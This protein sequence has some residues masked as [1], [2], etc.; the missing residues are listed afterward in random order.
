M[1][2]LWVLVA[3]SYGTL[4]AQTVTSF[5]GSIAAV[6]TAGT[7]GNSTNAYFGHQAGT[8]VTTGVNNTF[9][10]LQSGQSTTTG[11]ENSALGSL[12][13]QQNTTGARNTANGIYALYGN[14]IGME[15]TGIGYSTLGFN[16][17][18]NGN[19]AAGTRALLQ[20]TAGN[21]NSAIGYEALQNNFNSNYNIAMGYRSGQANTGGSQN[22]FLGSESGLNNQ[23]SGNIFLG[24]QAGYNEAG[25]N[26]LYID[27]SNT[28]SPLIWGD[29]AGNLLNLNASVGINITAPTAALDVNG[30]VRLR[31]LNQDNA[32]T[33][34]MVSDNNG[35]LNWR[36]AATLS[37]GAP[38]NSPA[39]TGIPTAP[40][41]AAGTNTTQLATTAFVTAADNLKANL[42]S[43]TFTGT[44][45][46]PT[47]VGNLTG[48]AT[49]ATTVTTNANLTGPV[50]SVGNVTSITNGAITN[51]MLANTAVA[52]LSGTNT[53]DQNLAPYALLNSPTF[54][55]TPAAPTAAAGTNT[56]QLATTAFVTAADNLKANLASPALTG[57]PTAPTAAPGTNTTQLATT[58][59]VTAAVPG[60]G[61]FPSYPASAGDGGGTTNAYFGHEAG[62]VN[63][64]TNNTF[65]GYRSGYN[66]TTGTDNTAYG[67]QALQNNTTGVGNVAIGAA[68]AI[69]GS[70]NYNT[71]V[72]YGAGYGAVFGGCTANNATAIG[73]GAQVTCG[74]QVRIGNNTVTSIGGA[75]AWSNPSD[76]RFK[77]NISEED[78]KGLAFINRLRPVV[79][80]FDTKKFTEFLTQTMP[81]SIRSHHLEQDF[82]PSTAI[83]QSGFIA[84]E[85]EKAAE[86]VGYNFN[87][88]Y[89]PRGQNDHYSLAYSQFVVPLVKGM[90]EQQEMITTQQ[91]LIETLRQEV[92][93]LKG[94]VMSGTI[95]DPIKTSAKTTGEEISKGFQLYQN[96]PNPFSEAT[97]IK[98]VVPES[99]QQAKILVYNLQGVELES[100]PLTE[101]G[102][103]SV[104]ISGGRFVSGMY[105]YALVADGKVIDTKKMI[106]TK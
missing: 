103:V 49:T 58:A 53:G 88:I 20:N 92:E 27:N 72:G 37:G 34:V 55:G 8:S 12:T 91:Q 40:T 19:I 25:S 4:N 62:L 32:L 69:G 106:L 7:T 60:G 51:A 68:I 74:D 89:K 50:T 63:T 21:Y 99:V 78:V 75:V 59:F 87:G 81:D 66:N 52:N 38:L 24:Y 77:D 23:G 17:T 76:G 70:G 79:Y 61:T 13:L 3:V 2:F 56:T 36:D 42:A 11:Y 83:R 101:R 10:G 54:T 26:R 22:T 98:A 97:I 9:V 33:R 105:L 44:V 31:T 46:A 45:T 18:G 57:I 90:Q 28:S 73:N 100:Y 84:Q 64:G 65:S 35:N 47:F 39:F 15:N 29:F 86:E 30:V 5:G 16:T 6:T 93:A 104:E 41:A 102:N 80:N 96:V 67:Y 71:A 14:T 94:I 95:A 1:Y 48:N 82:A 43:P 85:V